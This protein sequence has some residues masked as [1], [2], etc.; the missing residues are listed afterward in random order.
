VK[1]WDD[2]TGQADERR[3][4]RFVKLPPPEANRSEIWL[5]QRMHVVGITNLTSRKFYNLLK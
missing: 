1:Q 5:A 3:L 2:F 4:S